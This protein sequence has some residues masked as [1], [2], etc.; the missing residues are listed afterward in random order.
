V[1]VYYRTSKNLPLDCFSK[2]NPVCKLSPC[3]C[4][5]PF[6][7]LLVPTNLP[8][9]WNIP[10]R[11]TNQYSL[12][13][14]F[15]L[16]DVITTTACFLYCD[17]HPSCSIFVITAIKWK[18]KY[19]YVYS[20]H[21]FLHFGCSHGRKVASGHRNVIPVR[22]IFVFW[23]IVNSDYATVRTWISLY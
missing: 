16:L 21:C 10:S 6:Y 4:K 9:M 18:P 12:S 2:L 13:I 15:L 1:A 17:S 20:G 22:M 8:E 11:F 5:V 7:F 3:F 19:T 23:L 14:Y